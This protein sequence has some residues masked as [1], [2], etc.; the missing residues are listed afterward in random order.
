[1]SFTT[2]SRGI[3]I[4]YG[5]RQRLLD[6][7][8][9]CIIGY[10]GKR[11]AGSAIRHARLIARVRVAA[12]GIQR[13]LAVRAFG[14]ARQLYRRNIAVRIRAPAVSPGLIVVQDIAAHA[15]RRFGKTVHV[16]RGHRS[17]VMHRHRQRAGR[18]IAGSIRHRN[19]D[20]ARKRVIFADALT[21]VSLLSGQ[22]ITVLNLPRA[23]VLL[24]GARHRYLD[25]VHRQ[26]FVG[27]KP[28]L[29]E[30]IAV[31]QAHG[32]VWCVRP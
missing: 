29:V 5:D 9:V 32:N 1:M 16:A 21:R 6:R 10:V 17:V 19:A 30:R 18:C 22:A 31:D 23:V 28:I 4:L 8:T 24:R 15:H 11:I 3:R 7:V 27:G 14:T 12:V 26:C 25:A 2:G 13:Q 20:D